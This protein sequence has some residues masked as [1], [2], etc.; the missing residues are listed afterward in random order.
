M[1]DQML[2]SLIINGSKY[3]NEHKGISGFYSKVFFRIRSAYDGR[4]WPDMSI[5]AQTQTWDCPSRDAFNAE[6]EEILAFIQSDPNN[7]LHIH[8][9][10]F[11]GVVENSFIPAIEAAIA[12][13]KTFK[14]TGTDIYEE[15]HAT[16]PA[17]PSTEA[18]FAALMEAHATKRTNLYVNEPL[19]SKV[20]ERYSVPVLRSVELPDNSGS[21][22]VCGT[23]GAKNY[24]PRAAV[25]KVYYS[26]LEQGYIKTATL[27]KGGMGY[28]SAN[29]TEQ[30]TL[31]KFILTN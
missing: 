26:M 10:Q 5:N 1:N 21:V 9:C 16:L 27:M 14:L 25:S 8:P 3:V 12:S 23:R 13:A 24:V 4:D 15:V 19:V 30:R 20:A 22:Y 29:K 6:A 18:I 28:R 17:D 31:P 7:S 11:S 2:A